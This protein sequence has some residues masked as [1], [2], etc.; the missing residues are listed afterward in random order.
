M[1]ALSGSFLCLHGHKCALRYCE[2]L[3]DEVYIFLGGMECGI[4][5]YDYRQADKKLVRE[6]RRWAA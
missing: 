3:F 4:F 2:F 6:S 1:G 5:K